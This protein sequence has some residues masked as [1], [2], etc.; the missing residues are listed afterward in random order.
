M[1]GPV[2]VYP[3]N[4]GKWEGSMSAVF[5]G[6]EEVFYTVGI[7]RSAV[8]DDDLRRMEAQNLEITRF[9]EDAGIPCAQYLPYYATQAER[10]ARHFGPG[11]WDRFVQRKRK[12]DPKA[13]LSRGQRIFS[14]P[15]VA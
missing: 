5:P 12:C 11:R 10:A 3:M 14:N 8:A 13:I 1:H 9:C 7:L 4:R 6:E 2:L 15:P